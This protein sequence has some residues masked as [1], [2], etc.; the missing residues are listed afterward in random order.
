[1]IARKP[2]VLEIMN[3]PR[4]LTRAA[5]A[6]YTGMGLSNFTK[7]AREVGAERH[8]GSSVR[9]DKVVIDKA[10]DDMATGAGA[11]I[12]KPTRAEG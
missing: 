10:L 1:M 7:W 6:T 5:G 12:G 9:F 3:Q 2:G 8:F 4:M 11:G